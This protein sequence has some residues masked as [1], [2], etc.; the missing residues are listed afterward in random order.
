M[1]KIVT[2][3]HV[4]GGWGEFVHEETSTE[5]V[6]KLIQQKWGVKDTFHSTKIGT[7]VLVSFSGTMTQIG[8]CYRAAGETV[9]RE[10][11]EKESKPRSE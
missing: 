8:E 11:L 9:Y 7:K 5:E 6:G 10:W 1:I 4:R 3:V 2:R